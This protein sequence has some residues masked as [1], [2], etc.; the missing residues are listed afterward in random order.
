MESKSKTTTVRIGI[1][2]FNILTEVNNHLIQQNYISAK[3]GI[4]GF[5]ATIPDEN[6]TAKLINTEFNNIETE[7]K[8]QLMELEIQAKNEEPM[9]Q[10]DMLEIGRAGINL[11][12]VEN[13]RASLW[14]IS[15]KQGLFH[16]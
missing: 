13:Q 10:H 7:R 9:L 1:E 6:E 3:Q 5:L 11:R 4:D 16:E 2:R 14:S 15:M 12:A 8:T